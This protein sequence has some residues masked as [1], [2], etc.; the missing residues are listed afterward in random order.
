MNDWLESNNIKGDSM[1]SL[2][3]SMDISIQQLTETE[4]KF[5]YLIGLLPGG[6][7]ESDLDIMHG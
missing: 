5:F 6:C 7:T 2:K 4:L 1:G 3:V